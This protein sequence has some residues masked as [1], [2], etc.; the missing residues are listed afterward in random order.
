MARFTHEKRVILTLDLVGYARLIEDRSDV[1]TAGF[2]D[3]LYHLYEK[4]VRGGSWRDRPER[5]RAGY[6]LAYKPFQPVFNVGFRVAFPAEEG[7]VSAR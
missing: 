4:V 3:D 1:D 7:T 2:L 5:A 6:R